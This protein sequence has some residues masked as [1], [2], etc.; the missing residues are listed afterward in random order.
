M[1]AAPC[2]QQGE[3]MR[4]AASVQSSD[5]LQ[6]LI[7]NR[8]SEFNRR[9]APSRG[10]KYPTEL[11]ELVCR[12]IA[13]GIRLVDMKQLT[14]MSVT[15]IRFALAKAKPEKSLKP[16]R[17]EVVGLPAEMR[18]PSSPV[19]VRLPSGVCLELSDASMLSS[20]LLHSLASLDVNHATSR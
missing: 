4:L 12:G 17:L 2:H 7:K 10:R 6:I 5:D 13:A 14:G 8:F 16:R 1:Q 3:F 19:I 20:A 15:A 9:S 18:P 11:R